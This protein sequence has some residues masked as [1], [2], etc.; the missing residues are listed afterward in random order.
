[1]RHQLG[2][3]FLSSRLLP[4]VHRTQSALL[5]LLTLSLTLYSDLALQQCLHLLLP[6]LHLHCRPNSTLPLPPSPRFLMW[7]TMSCLLTRL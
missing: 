1:M 7:V 3:M 6:F 4:L 2:L 5:W